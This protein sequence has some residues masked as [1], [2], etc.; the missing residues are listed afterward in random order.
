MERRLVAG[1]PPRDGATMAS[2]RDRVRVVAEA[3]F[4]RDEGP[5]PSE[6]LDFVADDFID[7]LEQA[8]P[9]PELI[10]GSA[11]HL[12]TWVAPLVIRRR[13][14]LSRL[15][16]ADR[17]R[18]LETLEETPAGLPLLALKAIMCTIYYEH[19][20]ALQEIGVVPGGMGEVA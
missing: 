3:M 6:R 20:D 14:P 12:A 16:V 19:E 18:A 4:A 10:M 13:P 1:G 8:G 7:F 11:L 5:V 15:P 17:V 2:R 9:R